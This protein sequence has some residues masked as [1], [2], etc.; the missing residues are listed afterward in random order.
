M[1]TFPSF[2]KILSMNEFSPSSHLISS[3]V[4]RSW[5]TKDSKDMQLFTTLVKNELNRCV[6]CFTTKQSKRTYLSMSQ[7]GLGCL[8]CLRR[9]KLVLRLQQNLYMLRVLP[10]QSKLV[11]QQVT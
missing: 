3:S 2:F 6:V 8:S 10:A 5:D 11:L 4:P 1:T 9:K 7:V